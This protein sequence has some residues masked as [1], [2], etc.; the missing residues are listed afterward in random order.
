L[1]Q[2]GTLMH[3]V[4]FVLFGLAVALDRRYPAWLE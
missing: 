1:G 3:G 2:P 4:F